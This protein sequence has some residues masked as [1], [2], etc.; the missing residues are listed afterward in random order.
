ML[1][2]VVVVARPAPA[3]SQTTGSAW[4]AR[5]TGT[6]RASWSMPGPILATAVVLIIRI[7]GAAAGTGTGASCRAGTEPYGDRSQWDHTPDHD[8]RNDDSLRGCDGGVDLRLLDGCGADAA[9]GAGVAA[10]VGVPDRTIAP[11]DALTIPVTPLATPPTEFATPPVSPP[12]VFVTPPVTPP[13]TFAMPSVS[14]PTGLL[15]ASD[16]VLL[17]V[18]PSLDDGRPPPPSQA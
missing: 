15:P 2:F 14:P 18:P 6:P 3:P 11:P 17:V 9:V 4:I 1:V 8:G 13:T 12:T 5:S 16:G 7:L 10:D